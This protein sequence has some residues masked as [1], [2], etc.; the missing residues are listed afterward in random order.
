M[1]TT[2]E[3]SGKDLV[4]N[5]KF[6]GDTHYD[7]GI[8]EEIKELSKVLEDVFWGLNATSRQVKGRTEQSAKEI[9]KQLKQLKEDILWIMVNK[10]DVDTLKEI[11]HEYEENK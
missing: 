11:L 9:D 8:I 4:A 7:D 2:S 1:K 6:Y 10:Q 3:I 5:I